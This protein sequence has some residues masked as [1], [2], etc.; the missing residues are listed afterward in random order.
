MNTRTFARRA[1]AR[2]ASKQ[3]RPFSRV[4]VIW[5]PVNSVPNFVG[6]IWFGPIANPWWTGVPPGSVEP[7]SSDGGGVESVGG[8]VE[9]VGGG[10]VSTGGGVVVS[11]GGVVVVSGG[12]DSLD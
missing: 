11:G 4:A 9:S 5:V 12:G 2:S 6:G 7:Q 10:V 1:A 8:G 3:L